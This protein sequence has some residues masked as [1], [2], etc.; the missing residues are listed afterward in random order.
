MRTFFRTMVAVLLLLNISS[1][2]KENGNLSENPI[3]CNIDQVNPTNVTVSFNAKMPSNISGYYVGICVSSEDPMGAEFNLSGTFSDDDRILGSITKAKMG[4]SSYRFTIKGLLPERKYNVRAFVLAGAGGLTSW[5]EMT[6]F[7][8][9]TR[10]VPEGAVD[11]GVS[12]LWASCNL[13]ASKPEEFG[14]YYAW[15]ATQTWYETGY[16]QE[17]PQQHWKDGMQSGYSWTNAPFETTNATYSEDSK[18]CKYVGSKKSP[19]ADAAAP[20][21]DLLKTVLDQEDDAAHVIL[22]NGWRIPTSDEWKIL[23]DDEKFSMQFATIDGTWGIKV[24]SLIEGFTDNWIFLPFAG[25][26]DDDALY[27]SG[28]V[29]YFWASD[30]SMKAPNCSE[31]T[32]FT[33]A[34]AS[35]SGTYRCFGMS[36]RPVIE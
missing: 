27:Q 32:R 15:G 26:W 20:E 30:L 17:N 29:G 24:Q 2:Q 14:D 23:F 9:P 34:S 7:T 16:A 28:F 12:V 36:I 18:W 8:T 6:T 35:L 13:G 19:F 33:N 4:Q 10:I 3:R 31:Y 22:G 11:L 25:F 5:K 21:E 1:C